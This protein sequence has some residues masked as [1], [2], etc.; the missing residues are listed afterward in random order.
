MFGNLTGG[1]KAARTGDQ[2][3][4]EA[5]AGLA[6]VTNTRTVTQQFDFVEAQLEQFAT[7][8]SQADP[9]AAMNFQNLKAQINNIQTQVNNG[10]NQVE[11]SLRTID[12][13]TDKIQ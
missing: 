1:M 9:M 3:D 11:N 12:S 7:I 4:A 10:L 5:K 6:I 8:I 2:I 13:L